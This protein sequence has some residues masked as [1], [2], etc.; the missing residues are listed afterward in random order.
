M[1]ILFR[2]FNVGT[3]Y[4]LTGML[5]DLQRDYYYYKNLYFTYFTCTLRLQQNATLQMT[6]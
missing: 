4:I 5:Y 6:R 1:I 2:Y 3:L